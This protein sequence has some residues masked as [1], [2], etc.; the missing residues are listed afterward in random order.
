MLI[1]Q[2]VLK[3]EDGIQNALPDQPNVRQQP[4]TKKMGED[5]K[6]RR[7][8]GSG[9]TPSSKPSSQQNGI[10]PISF[11]QP[12][13]AKTNGAPTSTL[14]KRSE[15][16]YADPSEQ[17]RNHLATP[18]PNRA[19]DASYDSRR[20]SN[21]SVSSYGGPSPRGSATD[22][23]TAVN[24]LNSAQPGDARGTAR[25]YGAPQKPAT[26]EPPKS[27]ASPFARPALPAMKG[28]F[29]CINSLSSK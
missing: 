6:S 11:L 15:S 25:P 5:R 29:F 23:N 17:R 4:R 14:R 16:P 12:D 24:Q 9:T 18:S 13:S 20:D 8:G 2:A 19:R 1:V 21:S 28:S 7:H 22:F 27:T 26:M 10:K 3:H